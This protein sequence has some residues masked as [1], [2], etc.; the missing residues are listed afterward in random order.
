M[1]YPLKR[2]LICRND[3]NIENWAI[4]S[5]PDFNSKQSPECHASLILLNAVVP[6]VQWENCG[7]I[8]RVIRNRDRANYKFK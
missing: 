6:Y 5:N 7:V 3:D 4:I 8:Y 1:K 2:L